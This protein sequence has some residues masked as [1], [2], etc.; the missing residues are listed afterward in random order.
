MAGRA[1]VHRVDQARLQVDRDRRTPGGRYSRSPSSI[2]SCSGANRHRLI[3]PGATSGCDFPIFR[4]W[5]CS[6]KTSSS[7]TRGLTVPAA[8]RSGSSTVNPPVRDEAER[9]PAGPPDRGYFSTSSTAESSPSRAGSKKSS[10]VKGLTYYSDSS[11][12]LPKSA[13]DST[14]SRR[15]APPVPR[16]Q[17]I[18]EPGQARAPQRL[19]LPVLGRNCAGLRSPTRAAT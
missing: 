14:P 10:S 3:A 8:W 6:R 4:P 9:F 16:G 11:P 5:P 7:L 13:V 17:W 19:F 1:T 15:P 2:H 12:P 18:A